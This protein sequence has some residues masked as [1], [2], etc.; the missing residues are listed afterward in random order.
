MNEFGFNVLRMMKDIVN[1]HLTGQ[2]C[3]NPP[4]VYHSRKVEIAEQRAFSLTE[5]TLATSDAA[6]RPQ[7]PIYEGMDIFCLIPYSM[8]CYVQDSLSEC[9]KLR[10]TS[11]ELPSLA[12]K[13]LVLLKPC[14]A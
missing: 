7:K 1:K 13:W 3:E 11:S 9:L 6:N 8:A 10:L 2:F 4:P 5:K 14:V 12:L